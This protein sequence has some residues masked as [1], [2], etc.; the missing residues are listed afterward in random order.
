MAGNPVMLDTNGWFAI[1]N[2][3]DRLHKTAVAKY[4]ELLD[5]R[6][7]IFLTD[8]IIAETGN[9]L[10]RTSGRRTFRNAV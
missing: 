4:R 9:G 6:S 5:A 10:A 2:R 3:R 7:P 8:W 1:L